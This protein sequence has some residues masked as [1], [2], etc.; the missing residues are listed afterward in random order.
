MEK[1][2]NRAMEQLRKPFQGVKNIVR[3]NWHFYVGVIVFCLLVFIIKF[4]LPCQ[5]NYL[6]NIV[7]FSVITI[8]LI[9][10]AVSF[11][12]YDLSG[13]YKLN[14]LPNCNEKLSIVNIN[15]G[16][17][18]TS[19]L[20]NLKYPNSDLT[21]LDFYDPI[22][23]TEISIKRARKAYPIYPNTLKIKTASLPIE[24]S[25][26][27]KVFVIFSAHEIRNEKERIEFFNELKRII[28]DT[29]EIY[30]TEHLRDLPNF[31]AYNIGFM[32]FLD[33]SS[34]Y[35]VFSKSKLKIKYEQK[36]NPFI[37]N[38]TLTKYGN[39]A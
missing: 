20:L 10:L 37:T 33:L 7:L 19:E 22:R 26:M 2:K 15:A 5:L 8:T 38:F 36:L 39:T 4:N 35:S 13:L 31:L 25:S 12:V 14:W 32:H 16:F 11:Y 18:E 24:T 30:V 28:S 29:G 3:F 27:D 6:L 9:T 21:V 23:H 1:R 17:D 34:W